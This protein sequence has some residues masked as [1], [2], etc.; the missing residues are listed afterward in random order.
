MPSLS[1]S[2]RSYCDE[3]EKGRPV[4]SVSSEASGEVGVKSGRV[5]RGNQGNVRCEGPCRDKRGGSPTSKR[6][7]LGSFPAEGTS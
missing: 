5:R 6:S 2:Y 7:R 3:R 4:T 1:C